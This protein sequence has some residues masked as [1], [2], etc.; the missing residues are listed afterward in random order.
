MGIRKVLKEFCR[1]YWDVS[2]RT[3]YEVLDLIY[4]KQLHAAHDDQLV[5]AVLDFSGGCPLA[6]VFAER[7]QDSVHEA[8]F[9]RFARH[10]HVK[11]RNV[12]DAAGLRAPPSE[13]LYVKLRERGLA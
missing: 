7:F 11:D 1:V 2:R 5:E 12:H 6:R 13:V 10:L 3:A 8:S 4:K 9:R